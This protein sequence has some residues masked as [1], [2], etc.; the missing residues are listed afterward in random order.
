MPKH[1]ESESA[2]PGRDTFPEWWECFEDAGP[3]LNGFCIGDFKRAFSPEYVQL[4]DG[5]KLLHETLTN[6]QN[7]KGDT[8]GYLKDAQLLAAALAVKT[9]EK[10]IDLYYYEAVYQRARREQ[11]VTDDEE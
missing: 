11:G 3:I 9:F 6:V 10:L 1:N 2:Y 4:M 5:F 7:G 8:K